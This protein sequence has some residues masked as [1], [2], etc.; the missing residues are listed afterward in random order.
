[1]T[2]SIWGPP[3]WN[4]FHTLAQKIKEERFPELGQQLFGHIRKI[5]RYLP[6]PDCSD[7]AS[8]FLSNV[9]PNNLKTKQH[10]INLL[11]VMHNVVNK[12]KQKQLCGKDIVE[13]YKNKNVIQVYNNFVS[14]YKTRGNM[15]LMT[16]TFQR[17]ILMNEFKKWLV[18]NI[19]AFV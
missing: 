8:R 19:R 2:P 5:C 7:H 3:I 13:Q 11:F 14:V 1:M 17:Q 6:C 12:R 16:D 15:K 9:V 18:G 4:L 10:L